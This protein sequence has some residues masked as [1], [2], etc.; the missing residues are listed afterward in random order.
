MPS[1]NSRA[2]GRPVRNDRP[3][4]PSGGARRADPQAASERK[5]SS[6]RD[7]PLAVGEK[8]YFHCG[9]CDHVADVR[10]QEFKADI[11]T[12]SSRCPGKQD[13][14]AGIAGLLNC[15]PY[16]LLDRQTV[17]ACLGPWLCAAGSGRR[18]DDEP[19]LL[20]TEDVV[21]W[22]HERLLT[23][24][25]LR[26]QR[27][28]LSHKR[29]LTLET[30]RRYGIGYASFH[31]R[32]RAFMHPVRGSHGELVNL[33]ESYWPEP[34]VNLATGEELKARVLAGRDVAVY[35][36]EAL[37]PVSGDRLL[38][39]TEGRWKAPLLNQHGIRAVTS[40]NGT[41]WKPE[42]TPFLAGQQVAVLYDVDAEQ[43][44][45]KRADEFRESG[46]DAWAVFLSAAGFSGKDGADDALIR[47]G[48][49]ADDLLTLIN[50]DRRGRRR[51]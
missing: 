23:N 32:P 20:P 30:I 28:Y 37:A 5:P 9:F 49:T 50:S 16:Q 29:G 51:S 17:L 36:V 44:A 10:G 43:K 41:V 2:S 38:V 34:M 6:E 14:L 12:F 19:E 11:G 25:D 40:T 27:L 22:W 15:A 31:G 8:R 7:T 13:C 3:A 48:W 4:Q 33:I 42:W 39:V 46:I 1:A 35:P 24:R 21:A 45:R 26:K 47:A 18:E